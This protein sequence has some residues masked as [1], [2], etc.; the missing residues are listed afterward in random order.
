MFPFCTC[1]IHF[2]TGGVGG[3][4]LLFI[5]LFCKERGVTFCVAGIRDVDIFK[6]FNPKSVWRKRPELKTKNKQ[7]NLKSDQNLPLSNEDALH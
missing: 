2:I 1:I 6:H 5:Y 7:I 4:A 3:G